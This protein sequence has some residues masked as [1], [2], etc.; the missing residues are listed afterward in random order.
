MASM[1]TGCGPE[2]DVRG[3]RLQLVNPK[4]WKLARGRQ[5]EGRDEGRGWR[6]GQLVSQSKDWNTEKG[7]NKFTLPGADVMDQGEGK[8]ERFCVAR[9]AI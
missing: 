8:V 3:V 1:V 6:R 4:R 2:E 5:T 9:T 7:E